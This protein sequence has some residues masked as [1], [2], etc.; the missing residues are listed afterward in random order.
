MTNM[1]KP[2]V[3]CFIIQNVKNNYVKIRAVVRTLKTWT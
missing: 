2:F 1:N 3:L